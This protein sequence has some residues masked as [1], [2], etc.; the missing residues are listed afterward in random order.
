[1]LGFVWALRE[2]RSYIYG[3]RFLLHTGRSCLRWISTFKEPQ[4]QVARCLAQFYLI[5]MSGDVHTC[6]RTCTQCTR[7]KGPTKNNCAL[8]QAMAA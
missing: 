7:R 3:Q 4:G 6:C 8:M 1:M 5:W 2:F